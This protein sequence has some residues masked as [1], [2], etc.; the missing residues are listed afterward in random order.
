MDNFNQH[1]KQKGA[2]MWALISVSALVVLFALITIKLIPAYLDNNKV[3]SALESMAETPG[4]VNMSRNQ[5]LGKID[6]ILYIDMAND[7]LDLNQTLTITKTKTHKVVSIN[8]ERVIPM[9]YN[10]SALLDFENSVEIPLR[11]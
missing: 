7:L 10:L 8:Y 2:T 5:I 9:A 4:A 1:N 11:E 6:N 3:R